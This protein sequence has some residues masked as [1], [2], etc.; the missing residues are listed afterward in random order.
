MQTS[1]KQPSSAACL[2]LCNSHLARTLGPRS[3][4]TLRQAGHEFRV[5]FF[6]ALSRDLHGYFA[7]HVCAR[8]HRIDKVRWPCWLGNPILPCLHYNDLPYTVTRNSGYLINFQH[9]QLAL[10]HHRLGSDHGIPLDAF[11]HTEFSIHRDGYP[12]SI[13]SVEARI[14]SGELLLRSEQWILLP[15]RRTT[16]FTQKCIPHVGDLCYHVLM[17]YNGEYDL[18]Q[19]LQAQLNGH[20]SQLRKCSQCHLEFLLEFREFGRFRRKKQC[21]CGDEVDEL[22]SWLRSEG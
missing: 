5:G 12:T 1:Y 16:E 13:L 7:C 21:C 20:E 22:W 18:S 2:S 6:L 17:E 11:T 4:S 10:E 14:D 19:L 3:C 8:L 9:V 15:Q